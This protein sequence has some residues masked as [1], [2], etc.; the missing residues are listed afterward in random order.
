[1]YI[2]LRDQTTKI[3]NI[4]W[5]KPSNLF[6]M[7]TTCFVLDIIVCEQTIHNIVCYCMAAYFTFYS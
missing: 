6:F 3:E 1:M 5:I 4:G 7:Y 2:S